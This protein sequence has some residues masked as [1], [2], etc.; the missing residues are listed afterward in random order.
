VLSAHTDH[1]PAGP[2]GCGPSL[3][4]QLD[5]FVH[6]R[7][8]ILLNDLID[9]L[10]EHNG[11]RGRE[12][13]QL[14]RAEAPGLPALDALG[15]LCEALE[16]WPVATTGA[17]GTA[18]VVEWL[19]SEV[20]RAAASALGT[21]APTFMRSL[22]RA[23]AVSV[24]SQSYDPA[25][26]RSH[27]AYCYLRAGDA[28]AALEA[29]AT[30]RGR[31]LDPFILQ[32]VTLARHG[33]AGWHA[34]RAPL[35]TLA[36]SAP[37]HL[38]SVLM[39][40][41]DPSLHSDWERFWLDCAWLDPRDATAG[42]WFPAWYLIEHPARRFDEPVTAADLDT[43]PARAF[44]A[45]KLLLALEPSGYGAAL[46]SARAELR[47]INARLFEHYMSRRES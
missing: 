11:A 25:H 6:S 46:I 17:G 5:L 18:R 47:R 29:L 4:G 15:T 12:R 14:L 32:W 26:P 23:L 2:G 28:P 27:C 10:L 21:S 39:G 31:D 30:I 22:W 37:Q 42:A 43:S 36:L 45:T 24:A 8:V 20:A 16:R 41:A 40:L 3:K 33:T 1:E 35:F 44:Q 7:T 34:C 13:L 9:S 38:P 19:D